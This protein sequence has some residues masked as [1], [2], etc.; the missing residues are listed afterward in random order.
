MSLFETIRAQGIFYQPSEDELFA[1]VLR[2]IKSDKRLDGIWARALSESDMDNDKARATYIKLRVQSLRVDVSAFVSE[3]GRI[4]SEGIERRVSL[5][6]IAEHNAQTA[7]QQAQRII[8]EEENKSVKLK[9][10]TD[11]MVLNAKNEMFVARN[12]LL[13]VKTELETTTRL[14]NESSKSL[15][16]YKYVT[17][18]LISLLSAYCF[19]KFFG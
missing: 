17:W 16:D 13:N 5:L 7:A 9:T 11:E 3:L 4:E 8:L 19:W 10:T 18:I 12:E 14:L 6:E 2:E 15:S 1:E